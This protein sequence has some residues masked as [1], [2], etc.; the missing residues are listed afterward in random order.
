M[1]VT[2]NGFPFFPLGVGWT[3]VGAKMIL[4][5]DTFGYC[6]LFEVLRCVSEREITIR[7]NL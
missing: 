3:V 4:S 5:G 6:P 1:A 7:E 2:G